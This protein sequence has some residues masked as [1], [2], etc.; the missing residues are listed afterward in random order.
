[1]F[2]EERK[3]FPRPTV[4]PYR[5]FGKYPYEK[6]FRIAMYQTNV[7]PCPHFLEEGE[8]GTCDIF[9]NRPLS[10]RRY[11]FAVGAVGERRLALTVDKDCSAFKTPQGENVDVAEGAKIEK[12]AE[13]E[14]ATEMLLKVFDRKNRTGK[15]WLFDLKE[16]EW[17]EAKA[18]A[19][20]KPSTT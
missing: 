3:L 8:T 12:T 14:A 13:T 6:N 9:D 15:M 11:P 1:M 5:G 2:P 20:S 10:C 4:S 17:V 19:V 7:S 18:D 16:K